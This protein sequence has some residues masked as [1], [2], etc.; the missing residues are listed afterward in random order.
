MEK[1]LIEKEQ[2]RPAAEK[3]V[4]TPPSL[5][6]YGKLTELTAAGSGT[7]T[8]NKPGQGSPNEKP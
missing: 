7:K 6:S 5:K 4:Y 3:R 8:E 2:E 1:K